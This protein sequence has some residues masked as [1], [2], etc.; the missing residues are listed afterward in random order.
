LTTGT[1][2]ESEFTRNYQK[3]GIVHEY[4]EH[5]NYIGWK[6]GDFWTLDK[7]KMYTTILSKRIAAYNKKHA[8]VTRAL[9]WYSSSLKDKS[10]A[11]MIFY[12]K[13]LLDQY[14]NLLYAR[15]D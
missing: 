4:D 11:N 12:S 5:K 14:Y 2:Y 7:A 3:Y 1:H 15:K 8:W 9:D 6:H 10:L 13:V